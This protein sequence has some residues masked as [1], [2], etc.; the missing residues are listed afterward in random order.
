MAEMLVEL[1]GDSGDEEEEEMEYEEE[2]GYE[3]LMESDG[4]EE[5]I[6]SETEEDRA[7]LDDDSETEGEGAS[8][9]RAINMELGEPEPVQREVVKEKKKKKKKV[10]I[11]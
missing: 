7:F 8:F 4:E 3:D 10:T 11:F 9:Y 5:D 6:E 2:N 1:Q